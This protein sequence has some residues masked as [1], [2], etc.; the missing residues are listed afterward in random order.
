ML[1]KRGRSIK[2]RSA[3]PVEARLPVSTAVWAM[4]R[5]STR[6]GLRLLV[7]ALFVISVL[8]TSSSNQSAQAQA[9]QCK[10]PANISRPNPENPKPGEVRRTPVASYLMTLSWS[11]EYC[12]GNAQEAKTALQC[13]GSIGDFGFI[14]HGLW[15]E[16]AGPDYPQW[17][18]K[19]GLLSRKVVADNLCM[20]PSAQLLQHEWAKHGTCMARKP[21]T[22]FGAAKLIFEA[23]IFPDM[24]RLSRQGEKEGKTL[25]AAGLAEAFASNNEGLPADAVRV[26][27]NRKGWLEEVRVCLDKK[28]KPMRCPSHTRGAPGGAQVKVW[29]GG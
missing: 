27:T 18:R 11:R 24:D 5:P 8:A 29:R 16:A 22:Y 17:C 4:T 1:F 26:Q 19:A 10:A 25:T 28:F 3:E 13:N 12:R 9:W 6:S 23:I 20:T 21:E 7:A 14:L 15:P 2:N